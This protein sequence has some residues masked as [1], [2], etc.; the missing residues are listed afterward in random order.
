[1]YRLRQVA[2]LA[3]AMGIAGVS[4][5]LC[6]A[7]GQSLP[8]QRTTVGTS[9]NGR[10]I[11]VTVLGNGPNVTAIIGA[12]HG[13]EPQSEVMVTR[14][15]KHL[16]AHPDLLEGCTAVL[17]PA[18][19]PDGLNRSTRT[20]A[21]GV[22]INRNFPTDDWQPE[23]EGGAEFYPGPAAASEPETQAIMAL[24]DQFRPQKV[25]ATHSAAHKLNPTGTGIDLAQEM[26]KHNHYAIG[27]MGYR[28]PGSFGEYCGTELGLMMVTLEL[29]DAGPD[30]NWEQNR[31][32]LVAAIRYT[33]NAPPAP[34]SDELKEPAPPT[35]PQPPPEADKRSAEGVDR[36]VATTIAAIPEPPPPTERR[37]AWVVLGV[38]LV[39]LM[40]GLAVLVFA[41]PGRTRRRAR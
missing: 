35:P 14:L 21:Q 9:R 30:A 37:W 39:L 18:A 2:P 16:R 3:L 8:E 1:M 4:S 24:L 40:G 29:S 34:E 11:N 33:G 41:P 26:R 36:S 13:S 6:V 31:D 38:G 27:E 25:V 19:N 22:D 15:I 17:A 12:L 28:T 7:G 23:S 20:N 5:L 10:A 32:A